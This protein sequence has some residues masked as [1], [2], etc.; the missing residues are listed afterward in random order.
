MHSY[1][2]DFYYL[3][4]LEKLKPNENSIKEIEQIKNETKD[5]SYSQI[6]LNP[7]LDVKVEFLASLAIDA[8]KESLDG[9]L[10][11]E[12]DDYKYLILLLTYLIQCHHDFSFK[13]SIDLLDFNKRIL[14]IEN[15]FLVIC[16]TRIEVEKIIKELHV[17]IASYFDDVFGNIKC[18]KHMEKYVSTEE[19]ALSKLN[20]IVIK[21]MFKVHTSFCHKDRLE[22]LSFPTNYNEA[23]YKVSE[24]NV[25]DFKTLLKSY[26]KDYVFL[27]N[28]TIP[29]LGFAVEFYCRSKNLLYGKYDP[30]E[31]TEHLI[32]F[33]NTLISEE[34]NVYKITDIVI[35]SLNYILI[36]SKNKFEKKFYLK[37]K[38]Q[39]IMLTH[40][41]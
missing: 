7:D 4:R 1:S 17:V 41:N 38:G 19:D 33:G 23:E 36:E 22:F 40:M 12:E 24:L 28:T 6:I 11:I 31:E 18:L 13:D 2:E 9:P 20:K 37:Y 10:K 3:K 16:C 14:E 27:F 5:L 8:I 21:I 29:V 25:P 32:I 30:K 35:T 39:M 34:G 15:M 26:N